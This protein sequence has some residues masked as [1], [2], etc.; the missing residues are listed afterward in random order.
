M[1]PCW[2]RQGWSLGRWAESTASLH[3][4]LHSL[5][6]HQFQAGSA[7]RAPAPVTPEERRRG[8][9]QGVQKQADPARMFGRLPMPLTMRA[10]L[11]RAAIAEAGLID[12]A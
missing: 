9:G 8:D 3:L 11:T 10:Q 5:A 2:T 6:A 1:R 7:L 4:D 12:H